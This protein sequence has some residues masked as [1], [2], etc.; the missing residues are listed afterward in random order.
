MC[1]HVLV[2]ISQPRYLLSALLSTQAVGLF[3]SQGNGKTASSGTTLAM[4]SSLI[5]ECTKAAM[6]NHIPR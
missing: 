3:G 5:P 2:L 4:L 6:E 1:Y